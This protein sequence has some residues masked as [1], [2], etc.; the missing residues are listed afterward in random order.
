MML[1]RRRVVLIG[2]TFVVAVLLLSTTP[3]YYRAA[4]RLK[5][6]TRPLEPTTPNVVP[7]DGKFHWANVPQHYPV[8]NVKALPTGN[9]TSIPRIQY[10]FEPASSELRR[11][12]ADRRNAVKDAFL[13]GWRAYRYHAWG[14]DE[15]KPI[16]AGWSNNLEGWA[17]TLIDTV[18]KSIGLNLLE[19]AN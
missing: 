11:V 3:Q 9:P 14:K 13:Y 18:G 4:Y 16:S 8:K 17:V 15:L 6:H 1:S 2:L 5:Q 7:D 19:Y 10:A 12:R